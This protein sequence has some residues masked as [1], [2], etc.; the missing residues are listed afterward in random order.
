MTENLTRNG[1][2]TDE[3]ERFLCLSSA[4]TNEGGTVQDTKTRIS[5]AHSSRNRLFPVWIFKLLSLITNYVF[6]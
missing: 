6:F 4:L 2:T 5:K 1:R 3:V